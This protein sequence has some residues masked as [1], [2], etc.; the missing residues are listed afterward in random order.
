MGHRNS[1]GAFAG[2][3]RPRHNTLKVAKRC[4]F[5]GRFELQKAIKISKRIKQ[6]KRGRMR[7]PKPLDLPGGGNRI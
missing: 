7:S 6:K 2:T 4:Q 5:H 1:W 3:I